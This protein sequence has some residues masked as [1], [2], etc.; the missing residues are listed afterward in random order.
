MAMLIRLDYYCTA[1]TMLIVTLMN[2]LCFASLRRLC[3]YI[4]ICYEVKYAFILLS[5]FIL[6]TTIDALFVYMPV[7]YVFTFVHCT[8]FYSRATD[9]LINN[10]NSSTVRKKRAPNLTDF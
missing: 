9:A 8:A 2:M 3:K 7:L 4:D 6:L 1:A 10:N 5:C